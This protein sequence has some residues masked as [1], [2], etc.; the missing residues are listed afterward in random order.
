R[1]SK[2]NSATK[3]HAEQRIVRFTKVSCDVSRVAFTNVRKMRTNRPQEILSRLRKDIAAVTGDRYQHRRAR[4]V[5]EDEM[6]VGPFVSGQSCIVGGRRSHY[7]RTTG[8]AAYQ[9]RCKLLRR[10]S[11]CR[12]HTYRKLPKLRD[13]LSQAATN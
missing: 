13:I 12:C 8:P 5:V 10:N 1:F 6:V 4:V 11:K 2:R 9:H 3:N 7:W